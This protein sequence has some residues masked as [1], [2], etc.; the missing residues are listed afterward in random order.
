MGP[1]TAQ[2]IRAQG[3]ADLPII[4]AGDVQATVVAGLLGRE[5]TMVECR[6]TARRVVL[7]SARDG[8]RREALPGAV[9]D[10]YRTRPPGPAL[11]VS[12]WE[13]T[14]EE[15]TAIGAQAV[16]VT[17]LASFTGSWVDEE[18]YLYRLMASR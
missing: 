9:V 12:V 10:M 1:A 16:T 17:R 2:W 6:C 14:G 8:F 4:A 18:F 15:Q 13:L 11:L 5:M 7:N 3:L